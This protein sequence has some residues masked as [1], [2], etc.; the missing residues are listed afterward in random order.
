MALLQSRIS[1]HLSARGALS[2]ESNVARLAARMAE[3]EDSL[4]AECARW[5][6]QTPQSWI[7][8]AENIY[9]NLFPSRTAQ[10]LGYLRAKGWYTAR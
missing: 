5:G 9:N 8:S 1:M 6:Y 4:I 7:D 10:L 3:I 2:P